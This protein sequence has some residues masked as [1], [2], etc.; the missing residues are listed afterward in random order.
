MSGD[1]TGE[2]WHVV[3]PFE[4]ADYPPLGVR[5]RDGGDFPRQDLEVLDLQT[6]IAN[7][8]FRVCIEARADQDEFW[9]QAIGELLET[10]SKC[11]VVRGS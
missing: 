6:K 8:V 3:S 1:R 10:L 9:P 5:L 7:R 4:D 2:N 11:G